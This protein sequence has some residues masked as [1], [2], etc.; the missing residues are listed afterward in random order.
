[1]SAR[2]RLQRVVVA[3]YP[4]SFRHRYGNEL[5]AL[6]TDGDARWRDSVDLVL[7]MCRA[8]VAPTFGGAPVEQKRSRLQSTTTTVLF[9]WC[10][11]VLAAA[12]FSKAVDDPPLPGLHAV[13]GTAYDGGIVVVEVTAGLVMVAGFLFWLGLMVPALRARRREVAVPALAPALIVLVWLGITALVA[14]FAHHV[15]RRHSIA[16]TWPHG[17]L[18]LAV[19]V[20][21]IVITV[22]CVAGCAAA[23][24]LALRRARCGVPRL[25][26]ST[27]VAGIAAL[28][29]AAEAAACVICLVSLARP[30]GGL[31][32]RDAVFSVGAAFVVAA[33]TVIAAVSV[34]RGLGV[35][36]S[37]APGSLPRSA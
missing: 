19:L 5:A 10:A 11:S 30:A 4:P 13:A 3:S 33:A 37:D 17:A 15:V 28:G 18:V 36:R 2:V 7:G 29:I 1:M 34:A 26:V 32:P 22:A 23:A 24:T 14:L 16:L 21:W 6:V 12:V 9:A 25:A 8:W 31:D 27:V 35:L 20:T